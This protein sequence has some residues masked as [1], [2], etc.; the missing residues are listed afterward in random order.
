MNWRR[1]NMFHSTALVMN[2]YVPM[3][4]TV[5]DFLFFLFSIINH[6]SLLFSIRLHLR[7]DRAPISSNL[8]LSVCNSFD[9]PYLCFIAKRITLYR[10]ISVNKHAKCKQVF[11]KANSLFL[12]HILI[13]CSLRI[14]FL[15]ASPEWLQFVKLK[16]LTWC[17]QCPYHIGKHVKR[18]L[19]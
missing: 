13:T 7:C 19:Y 3:L 14:P 16:M 11:L 15:P 12:T 2:M 5:L 1:S 8:Y 9:F 18:N 6:L 10:L 17:S 4:V